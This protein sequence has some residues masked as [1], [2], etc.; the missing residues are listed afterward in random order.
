MSRDWISS[1]KAVPLEWL[2]EFDNPPVR[3]F[4]MRDLLDYKKNDSDLLQTKESLSSYKTIQRIFSEQNY[5]GYWESDE[6]PYL[7][8]YKASYWQLMLL[9]MFGLEKDDPHVELAFNHISKFQHL[10]GGFAE[11]MEGGARKEDDYLQN[12]RPKE[13]K[14][15]PRFEE[16]GP[17][18]IRE[19]QLSCLTGNV[20]LALIRLGYY[21]NKVVKKALQW[22]L[23]VQNKDGGWLCPY[24][25]TH[26]ND[27]HGCFMG[28]ITPLDAFSEIPE[29]QRSREIRNTI[30]HGAEFLLMHQLYKSDHHDF[31]V[32]NKRWLKLC[33]P[34]FFYDILR[35]LDV[36]TKLEYTSDD[37]IN[38]A[39]GVVLSKQNELGQWSMECSY[40]GRIHG[41][42]EQKDKPSKWVTL[43]VLRVIK[44]IVQKRGD[45]FSVM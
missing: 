19:M 26:K 9:G 33:F 6:T 25:G 39:L 3:Y 5:D 38:D 13:K 7:P 41:T 32:I 27:T 29:S 28:T 42:I 45:L 14:Q 20:S 23:Q 1:L 12:R 37:R 21:K 24:W 31:E 35:G 2:L 43:N 16:W 17:A 15:Y 30:Q 10:E 22:L 18:R 8:K 44:R 36:V 40:T 4:T 11:F 34:Q